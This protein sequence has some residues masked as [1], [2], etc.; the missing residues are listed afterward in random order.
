MPLLATISPTNLP[1][2]Y[3]RQANDY[4]ALRIPVWGIQG[5]FFMASYLIQQTA[6]NNREYTLG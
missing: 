4:F 6:E 1:L 2:P 3:I 5:A